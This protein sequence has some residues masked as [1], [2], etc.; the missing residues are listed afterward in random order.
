[1]PKLYGRS[2]DSEGFAMSKP[3]GHI[4]WE[5]RLSRTKALHKRA[6]KEAEAKIGVILALGR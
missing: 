1:M 5:L 6:G 2:D 4:G 3:Y